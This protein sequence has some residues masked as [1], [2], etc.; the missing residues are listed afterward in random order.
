MIKHIVMWKLQE[1]V[2]GKSKAESA[3]IIKDSLEGL[4]GK[5]DEIIDIEVGINLNP[6]EQ[7]YDV[8]LYSTFK[9]MDDL[10]TYQKHP[11]HLNVAT[12]VRKAACS[13]VV[14]DYEV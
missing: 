11:E 8:V 1:D 2:E 5:V 10:N 14:V 4:K 12:F 13:R 3:K 6:S 9:T 7:A